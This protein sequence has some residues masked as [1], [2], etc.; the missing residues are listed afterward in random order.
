MKSTFFFITTF[1]GALLLGKDVTL[2]NVNWTLFSNPPKLE[3]L[4]NY[5]WTKPISELANLD[6]VT[7]VD[8]KPVVN[9]INSLD[10][11]TQKTLF[12]WIKDLFTTPFNIN[13][14]DSM[15]SALIMMSIVTIGTL[16]LSIYVNIYQY[17]KSLK[18]D[19][20]IE[21]SNNLLR[22]YIL[23]VNEQYRLS[24]ISSNKITTDLLTKHKDYLE[25][26]NNKLTNDIIELKKLDDEILKLSNKRNN[27][28]RISSEQNSKQVLI[29][30][31]KYAKEVNTKLLEQLNI[32]ISSLLTI[33]HSD[34]IS[35]RRNNL[36]KQFKEF[37]MLQ[38]NNSNTEVNNRRLILTSSSIFLFLSMF[39]LYGYV[40]G[41]DVTNVSLFHQTLV[42]DLSNF[43]KI[44]NKKF[45][46]TDLIKPLTDSL[47]KLT[48]NNIKYNG[49]INY[50][51]IN[52]NNPKTGIRS[53]LIN[54]NDLI[55]FSNEITSDIVNFTPTNTSVNL[56][57]FNDMI[58]NKS[59]IDVQ[60]KLN[61]CK[62]NNPPIKKNLINTI[63]N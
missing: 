60:Q 25:L 45:L 12:T 34:F 24:N 31:E 57:K 18:Q 41:L 8:Y 29:Y 55:H 6:S 52:L 39:K 28:N 38:T 32:K 9:T 62:I 49:F 61:I 3:Y 56:T 23:K 30:S 22:D 26:K 47:N 16:S 14:T 5:L 59:T 51:S 42:S 7:N 37:H 44:N 17:K 53:A 11:K 63:N 46:E 35:S 58:S 2:F 50:N 33:K 43:C 40:R 10:S 1:C 27:D 48:S 21:Q 19:L 15:Y 36:E 20:Y 54:K 13:L 4:L